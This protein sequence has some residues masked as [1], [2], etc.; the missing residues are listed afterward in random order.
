MMTSPR[1]SIFDARPLRAVEVVEPLVDAVPAELLELGLEPAVER[2][3]MRHLQ[4][5]LAGLPV[6]DDLD[7]VRDPLEREAVGDDRPRVELAGPE[8]PPHLVPGLV[9][10]PA[11][12]AVEREAL[13]D[14]VAREV[15]FGGAARR[16]QQVDPAAQ[17]RR[18]ERLGMPARV[19]A[20]LADQVD[21]VA[22][23]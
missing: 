20:H 15:H 23:R 1:P 16:A 5:H 13:E 22:V 6:L 21:P 4:D 11:G 9:H 3:V 2:A 7:R 8:E 19:A 12:D 17:S 10:P 14:H 18:G